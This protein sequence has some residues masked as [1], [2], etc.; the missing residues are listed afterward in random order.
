MKFFM[1]AAGRCSVAFGSNAVTVNCTRASDFDD[2]GM[3]S[4]GF[5]AMN[6]QA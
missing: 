4:A 1:G 6:S 5:T 2:E 3:T